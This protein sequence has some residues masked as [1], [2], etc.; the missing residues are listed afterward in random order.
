MEG[1]AAVAKVALE[2]LR[3]LGIGNVQLQVGN[4]DQLLPAYLDSIPRLD[5]GFVDGNHRYEPTMR[6]F[7]QMLTKV[8]PHTVLVFD[9][10]H[11]SAEMEQ[12]WEEIKAHPQVT[13]TID[14]FFIGLVFFR[15]EQ[16][17]KEHFAIRYA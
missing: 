1:A 12:A 9:D 2:N 8:H 13:L 3:Q 7:Q 10:V 15:P 5:F 16:Q 17:Q 11:W 6:Y 4:F 14:L